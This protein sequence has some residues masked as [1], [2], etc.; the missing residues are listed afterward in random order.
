MLKFQKRR[1]PCM[2]DCI[3][4]RCI[5]S[6]PE[7]LLLLLV[8]RDLIATITREFHDVPDVSV[9]IGICLHKVEKDFLHSFH[10]NFIQELL[11]ESSRELIPSRLKPSDVCL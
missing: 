11:F 4:N 9:V 5:E 10:D 8:I 7:P 1:R 2:C 3:L 6:L